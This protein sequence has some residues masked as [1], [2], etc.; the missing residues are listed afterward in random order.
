MNLFS[1]RTSG[2]S[3]LQALG[4]ADPETLRRFPTERRRYTG[5]GGA[6]L[7]TG[8]FA[9]L[10]GAVFLHDFLYQPAALALVLGALWGVAIM[11]LD[12]WML[13]STRRQRSWQLTLLMAGPRVLLAAA[14]GFVIAEP[15]VLRVF[16]TE[17]QTEARKLKKEHYAD[18][19]KAI[20]TQ[21]VDI[22]S[23]QA[24][25]NQLRASVIPPTGIVLDGNARYQQLDGQDKSMTTQLAS[26]RKRRQCQLARQCSGTRS[27]RRDLQHRIRV[28]RL[29]LITVR[30][31]KAALTKTLLADEDKAHDAQEEAA[32]IE[33]RS[34]AHELAQRR[35]QRVDA[36][37]GARTDYRARIGL[38]DRIAALSQLT[39]D[40]P[41]T[42]FFTWMLRLLILLID[43]TPILFK[44]LS[45]LG[46][47]TAAELDEEDRER[48]AL[49][50]TAS[51]RQREVDRAEVDRKKAR[52]IAEDQAK[53]DR[54]TRRKRQEALEIDAELQ[55]DEAR[56]KQRLVAERTEEIQRRILD[57]QTEVANAVIERWNE[58]ALAAVPDLVDRYVSVG[59][60]APR[61]AA[62]PAPTPDPVAPAPDPT[63]PY[64]IVDKVPRERLR[65][66]SGGRAPVPP[67]TPPGAD[68][69]EQHPPARA[70]GD[71]GS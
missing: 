8:G 39:H 15:V 22:K 3:P 12:R 47:P 62:A 9:A 27:S 4:G 17:V 20:E 6:I 29:Q 46:K 34:A 66:P 33:L 44:A 28:L 11:N 53:H 69:F 16:H 2:L 45:L 63:A 41:G 55:V 61:T 30:E 65:G 31:S 64:A 68:P 10:A 24:H 57:G 49:E 52:E 56:T 14:I 13:V 40:E 18:A 37:A 21:Y 70:A 25:V 7:L 71:A 35:Q 51:E 23:L 5:V 1:F 42:A 36:L 38:M 19:R 58:E 67:A 59:D 54:V 60:D 48:A 50:K 32:R 26:L 43:L